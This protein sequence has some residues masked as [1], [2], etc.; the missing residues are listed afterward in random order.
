[1]T[2]AS[3]P[4]I[5]RFD[6]V[7]QFDPFEVVTVDGPR[8]GGRRRVLRAPAG[9]PFPLPPL[10]TEATGTAPEAAEDATNAPAFS[11]DELNAAV[12]AARHEA[13]EATR[14]AVEAEMNATIEKRQ[15]DACAA[16]ARA[17]AAGQAEYDATV[18]AY[19]R[20]SHELGLALARAIVPRALAEAPLA[21]IEAML[22]DVVPR[23]HGQPALELRLAPDLV[24]G[25]RGVL[26]RVAEAAGYGGAIEVVADPAL[27]DGDARLCWREGVAERDIEHIEAEAVRL[28]E[29]CLPADESGEA[30]VE[31]DERATDA[32]GVATDAAAGEGVEH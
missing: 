26:A 17:L 28:V 23:L 32:V 9:A 24:E 7:E 21:D 11:E 31:P 25:G 27:G 13:E 14:T 16:I 30:A 12:A 5:G 10:D 20:Q 29:A 1:M 19:A 18:K 8:P 2:T 3:M 6:P 4:P 15:A 22:E